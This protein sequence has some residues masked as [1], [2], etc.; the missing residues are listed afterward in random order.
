ML[1]AAWA[2]LVKAAYLGGTTTPLCVHCSL[3]IYMEVNMTKEEAI[4]H[5]ITYAYFEDDIPSQVL[6]A[7][8]IAI[9]ALRLMISNN[10]D[11]PTDS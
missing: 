1:L 6:T 10:I 11:L 5:I 2:A 3:F 7:F 4:K 9:S 8:D